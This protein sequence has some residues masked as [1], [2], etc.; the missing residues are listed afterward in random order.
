MHPPDLPPAAAPLLSFEAAVTAIQRR[1]AATP[2][3][4]AP[5]GRPILMEH[6]EPTEKVFVLLHGLSNAPVQFAAL[7]GLLHERGHTVLIPRLP[8][9]GEKDVMT[10]DWAA[11]TAGDMLDTAQWA[12]DL[13]RSLG[14][15]VVVAGLSVNGTVAAWLAQRRGD[16]ARCIVMAP[17][18]APAG[19][20]VWALGLLER[21]LVTAPNVFLWW[22]LKKR[23]RIERPR[24]AYPRF[25]TRVI[26]EAMRMGSALLA[27]ARSHPPVCGSILVVTTASDRAVSNVL[28][29]RL[30]AAWKARRAEAVEAYE[31]PSG[32]NVP[33]DFI[34][35]NQPNQVVALVYPRLLEMMESVPA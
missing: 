30:T 4:V 25:P 1:I 20:P 18:L 34:D 6:G 13:A 26:G 3:T 29:A 14:R 7:G 17:L 35:P 10:R 21:L 22:S 19:I 9:H 31:F 27:E 8:Y 11:L 24:Y 15:Q 5:E 32:E 2:E 16:V 12:V 23:A 33:H 28:T